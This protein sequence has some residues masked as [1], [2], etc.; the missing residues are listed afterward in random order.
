MEIQ[1]YEYITPE[2][3]P[4]L[5]EEKLNLYGNL[6]WEFVT[7]LMLQKIV[8]REILGINP[9]VPQTLFTLIF[10]RS[11]TESNYVKKCQD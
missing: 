8:K 11:L 10:R 3:H 4:N 5:L 7:L 9:D 1:K 2:I 6:G